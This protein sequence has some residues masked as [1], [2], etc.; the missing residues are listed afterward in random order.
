MTSYRSFIH[1][2]IAAATLAVAVLGTATLGVPAAS[3]Q[4]PSPTAPSTPLP[5][6][7]SISPLQVKPG[8]TEATVTFTTSVPTTIVY[9]ATPAKAAAAPAAASQF[10]LGDI[11]E[12]V[13]EE[14]PLAGGYQTQYQL[15]LK[16]LQSYTAYDLVVIATTQAGERLTANTRFT[17][18]NKRI[19]I[20]LESIDITDDGDLIGKGEAEWT[21]AL[22]WLYAPHR[23]PGGTQVAERQRTFGCYPVDCLDETSVSEGRIA[24]R[25]SRGEPLRFVFAQQN[26]DYGLPESIKLDVFA[27]EDDNDFVEAHRIPGIIDCITNGGCTVGE[28]APTVWR[29]PQDVEYASQRIT[30]HSKEGDW[31]PTG[32]R[33]VLT[34]HVEVFHDNTPYPAPRRNVPHQTWN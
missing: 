11:L 5:V 17:T 34:F 9:A 31:N 10:G 16:N 33:S 30:V 13:T 24:P 4:R 19:G 7:S 29:V 26:F 28:D 8:G 23:V 6:L 20:T 14:R 15:A 21:V 1:R 2:L 22:Q 18:L 3:A 25:N 12:S 32:F 27:Y